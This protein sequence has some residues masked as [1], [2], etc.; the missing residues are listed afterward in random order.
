[1]LP[2]NDIAR[3]RIEDWLREADHHRLVREAK[4]AR[5]ASRPE[6]SD[7]FAAVRRARAVAF[8]LVPWKREP[9]LQTSGVNRPAQVASACPTGERA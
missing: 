5:N 9:R 2:T 1:M 8:R 6:G 3:L 4:A 7:V